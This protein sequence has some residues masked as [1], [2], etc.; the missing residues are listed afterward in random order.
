MSIVKSLT[1]TAFAALMSLQSLA[2]SKPDKSVSSLIRDPNYVCT[3]AQRPEALVFKTTLPQKAWKT[4]VLKTG[5]I[6]KGK[7]F[8]LQ[9]LQINASAI[10]IEGKVASFKAEL[11]KN[12]EI[13]GLFQKHADEDIRLVV[14]SKYTP[15][16][17]A[18]QRIDSYNCLLEK[19]DAPPVL[20]GS[21]TE[22]ST[23]N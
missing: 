22:S 6:K 13:K 7:A 16:G 21:A 5:E 3:H 4:Q 1:A 14:I 15:E 20:L 18:N 19:S 2:A 11:T 23:T 9:K 12:Y 8:E 17:N 10:N